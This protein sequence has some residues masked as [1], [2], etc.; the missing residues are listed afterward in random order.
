MV[1]DLLDKLLKA[2]GRNGFYPVQPQRES[3]SLD[4]LAVMDEINAMENQL[5]AIESRRRVLLKK[6][7]SSTLS[8]DSRSKLLLQ[9][10]RL[11]VQ[12]VKLNN[13]IQERW[14]CINV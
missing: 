3:V 10:S 4:Q 13:K 1:I 2:C 14:R 6:S 5:E 7:E 9:A 8:D 12:A 11:E